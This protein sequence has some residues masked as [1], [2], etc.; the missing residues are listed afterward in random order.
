MSAYRQSRMPQ[1]DPSRGSTGAHP[2]DN[3]VHDGLAEQFAHT[4]HEWGWCPRKESVSQAPFVLLRVGENMSKYWRLNSTEAAVFVC[5]TWLCSLFGGHVVKFR[6][7]WAVCKCCMGHVCE[8]HRMPALGSSSNHLDALAHS[9]L[10]PDGARRSHKKCKHTKTQT[11]KRNEASTNTRQHV[12]QAEVRQ[13]A[14][15]VLWFVMFG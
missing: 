3:E 11:W 2:N 8:R 13:D 7:A 6:E 10:V 5:C 1:L 9:V 12:L 15:G 14:H 4:P